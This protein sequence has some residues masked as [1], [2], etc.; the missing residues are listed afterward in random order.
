M[1]MRRARA[2]G[3]IEG[4]PATPRHATPG[5]DARV[6][7]RGLPVATE[8][9][10]GRSSSLMPWSRSG[11]R[12]RR[13]LGR[14][15][16]GEVLVVVEPRPCRRAPCVAGRPAC[17]WAFTSSVI[18]TM[19]GMGIQSI[20][21]IQSEGTR[22]GR[23]SCL[24]PASSSWGIHPS[25]ARAAQAAGRSR[26]TGPCMCP[27]APNQRCVARRTVE[28]TTDGANAMH[29]QYRAMPRAPAAAAAACSRHTRARLPVL[30][31]SSIHMGRA[32]GPSSLTCLNEGMTPLSPIQDFKIGIAPYWIGFEIWSRSGYFRSFFNAVIFTVTSNEYDFTDE[33]DGRG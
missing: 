4:R 30:L 7:R 32:Y 1:G 5:Y 23:W 11:R 25:M 9:A 26:G 27:P 18:L 31:C 29:V 16:K 12:R 2:C 10:T 15:G 28:Y 14:G 3:R 8:Q 6:W 19:G 17:R 21:M 33:L 13:R 24:P 22:R 20:Q